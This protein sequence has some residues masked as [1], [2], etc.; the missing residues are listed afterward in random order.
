MTENEKYMHRCLQLASN[1]LG[2]TAP[3]PMVGSV[4]VHQGMII[5][6]GYHVKCGQW[7]AER[8]AIHQVQD[9]S[10]LKD[11]T[12]Y[13]NLEPCSHFGKTPPCSDLILEMK[14]P[15]V[16]MGALDSNPKVAGK[17]IEK[18]RQAG[19]QVITGC[20]ELQSRELNKRF[21][22]FHE[23]KRPYI[24]LKWAQTADGFIDVIRNTGHV[25]T[26]ITDDTART[27]VHKWRT[28]EQGILVGTTTA[29]LDNPKL[30]VRNW[31]GANPVRMVLDRTLRLPTTL[32]LFDDS[33]PTIVFTE[34][35]KAS[36]ALTEYASVAFDCDL[37]Q[38]IMNYCYQKQIH[39]IIIEGGTYTLDSFIKLNLWDEA[40]IFT[41]DTKFQS[42]IG[43]PAFNSSD[44]ISSTK[45]SNSILRYY[46]NMN[47]V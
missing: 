15:R 14:I 3:N 10:L 26:W 20:L 35:S 21:F 27:L 13:V 24:I 42:G 22:T 43:A 18:L 19:T 8:N 28:E 11:S 23:K 9:K 41:G 1:G 44:F 25:P 40:R 31:H 39:S 12:L 47:S 2:N 45:F 29:L 17:G 5:G 16:V 30:N 37:H 7:H 36:T 34:K 4:I 6:E 32:R 46:R 38:H 33:Q